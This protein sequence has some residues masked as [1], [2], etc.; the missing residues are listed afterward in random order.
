MAKKSFF[1]Q[2]N[3]S[4]ILEGRKVLEVHNRRNLVEI[5][6]SCTPGFALYLKYPVL[7][8]HY[9]NSKAFLKFG[10]EAMVGNEEWI[11]PKKAIAMAL[12]YASPPFGSIA[13]RSRVDNT[14]VTRTLLDTCILGMKL[15]AYSVNNAP[16]KVEGP[17]KNPDAI[18]E[19][20]ADFNVSVPSEE[21]KEDRHNVRFT[22]VPLYSKYKGATLYSQRRLWTDIGAVCDCDFTRWWITSRYP[23]ERLFCQ[24]AVAA[25]YAI[26]ADSR[27]KGLDTPR[28]AMPFPV[29]SEEAVGL[30]NKTRTQLILDKSGRRLPSNSAERSLL[31][32]EYT[33]KY[34]VEQALW[35]K[36]EKKFVEF[37]W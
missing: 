3:V 22:N 29:F 24:H 15:Y 4:E 26:A 8:R 10:G 34:D 32:G 5:I 23:K 33:W 7:P 30:W 16:I 6:N 20:G 18:A 1:R 9:N 25:Y 27:K 14:T 2:P 13:V 19:S 37:N 11:E 12:H 31:L 21:M 36:G 35:H 17:Y 28:W